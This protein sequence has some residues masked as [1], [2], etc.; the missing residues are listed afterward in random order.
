M[1]TTASS[2]MRPK[3]QSFQTFYERLAGIDLKVAKLIIYG[4]PIRKKGLQIKENT[5][6]YWENTGKFY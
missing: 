1:R 5:V 4:N 6:K 2:N 3:K